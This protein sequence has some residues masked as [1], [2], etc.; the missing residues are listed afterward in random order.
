[1]LVT[2]LA[3]AALTA[4]GSSGHGSSTTAASRQ[5]PKPSEP[6]SAWAAQFVRAT[7][8]GSCAAAKSLLL[9]AGNCQLL[10]TIYQHAKVS[11][12]KQ[13]GTGAAVDFTHTGGK[14]GGAITDLLA[15]N[16]HGKWVLV[17]DIPFGG[18][19]IGTSQAS[20]KPFLTT[21]RLWWKAIGTRNCAASWRYADVS[22]PKQQFCSSFLTASNPYVQVISANQATKPIPLGGTADYEFFGYF[23]KLPSSVTT[24]HQPEGYATNIVFKVPPGQHASY[25]YLV[26]NLTPG[27][28][29]KGR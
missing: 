16:T 24:T 10:I 9:R 14:T 5:I 18:P 29:L 26:E 11:G 23:L 4:C 13:F 1:M 27:P 6:V 19:S 20:V 2:V 8:S 17:R 22:E 15:L 7:S 12:T 28:T 25:P 21:D 3:A